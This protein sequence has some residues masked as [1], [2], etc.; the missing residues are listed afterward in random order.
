MASKFIVFFI[1]AS[2]LL[3]AQSVRTF[4]AIAAS[5]LPSPRGHDADP[6]R[7]IEPN[8]T[9]VNFDRLASRWVIGE[10]APSRYPLDGRKIVSD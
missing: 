8:S 7:A 5:Q 10:S 1:F 4:E 2:Y 6:N 3:H 9:L